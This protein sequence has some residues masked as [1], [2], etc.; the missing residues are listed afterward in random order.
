MEQEGKINLTEQLE[1]LKTMISSL[2][3]QISILIKAYEDIQRALAILKEPELQSATEMKTLIGAG[4]YAKSNVNMSESLL[5]P[6]GSDLYI[7]EGREKAAARL[8]KNSNEIATSLR[9]AQE[10]R[11]DL[12]SRHDSLLALYQQSTKKQ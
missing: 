7:E 3:S 10:R 6:I 12:A 5:V 4:I 9:D 8:E 2:D 1:Y 11:N